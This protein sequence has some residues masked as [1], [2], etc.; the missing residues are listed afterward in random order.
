VGKNLS[1]L[2]LYEEGGKKEDSKKLAWGLL[3]P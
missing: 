3:S 2:K 1:P